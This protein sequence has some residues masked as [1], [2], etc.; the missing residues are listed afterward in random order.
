[1][2]EYNGGFP[3]SNEYY[4]N[5]FQGLRWTGEGGREVKTIKN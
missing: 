1:M 3:L 4:F 2:S 5:R